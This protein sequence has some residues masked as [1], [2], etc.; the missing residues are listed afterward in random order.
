[1]LNKKSVGYW[2]IS[3]LFVVFVEILFRLSVSFNLYYVS[4]ILILLLFVSPVVSNIFS[5]I[6]FKKSISR[7]KILMLFVASLIFG[8]LYIY[9]RSSDLTNVIINVLDLKML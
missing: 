7:E 6:G 4:S 2:V 9:L 1:M 8:Y 3:I 5:Y